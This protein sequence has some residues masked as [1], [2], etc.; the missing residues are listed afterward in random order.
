MKRR[1][2]T[3][4]T[5]C[6]LSLAAGVAGHAGE[7]LRLAA[8][9]V[10]PGDAAALVEFEGGQRWLRA[11]DEAAGCRLLRVER[12]AA[13]LDC[14]THRRGLD[15][16]AG[17]GQPVE[18]AHAAATMSS[19]ELPPGELQSLAAR[20]QVLALAADFAPLVENG[21]LRGWTISRLDPEGALAGFGL[22][23]ADVV[24]AVNG[25]PAAT[26]VAF[27]AAVRALPGAH[28]F[29]LELSRDGR[30]LTLLV[31]APPAPGR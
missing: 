20:P 18:P 28:A 22:R 1:C 11:G 30:P 26:P 21:R 29:T 7:P 24:E 8:T 12:A 16:E 14:G 4:S 9:L 19:V 15:L 5:G 6:L 31:T 2:L 25:A 13:E 27:A 17:A 10:S 23:E 3:W